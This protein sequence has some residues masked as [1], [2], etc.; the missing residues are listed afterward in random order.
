[1]KKLLLFFIFTFFCQSTLYTKEQTII[2][3][4]F[5]GGD[6]DKV[7]YKDAKTAM[8]IWIKKLANKVGVSSKLL[9]YTDFSLLKQDI[10]DQKID[11][12]ILSPYSYLHHLQ[13]CKKYF[14]QG[15]MKQE[16]DGKPFYKY[17]LLSKK[18]ID[19]SKDEY[20]L[21]YYKYSKISKI[22]AQT[23]SWEH[24]KKF[25]FQQ[26]ATESKPVLN[27]FFGKC[28]YAIVKEKTW[29]LM[30]ELNPQLSQTLQTVYTSPR[31]FQ[32]LIAL[33]SKHLNQKD[34]DAYYKAITSLTTTPAGKQL[35]K[36]FKFNGLIYFKKDQLYPLEQYYKHY[37]QLKERY[38]Q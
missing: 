20:M 28:D 17:V 22:I 25:I 9:F 3:N 1:M 24:Q 27:L 29:Y 7:N 15:W 12:L 8:D 32:D 33:F 37:L 23:Y 6:I 30:Q 34:R 13:F 26:T 2:I 5:Y 10:K 4:A 16:K 18:N 31:I 38:A 36:L 14:Y 21:H 35:M 11:A 19:D